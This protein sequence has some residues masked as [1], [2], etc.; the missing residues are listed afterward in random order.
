MPGLHKM[1]N[2]G[3]R[4]LRKLHEDNPEMPFMQ[5]LPI[6]NNEAAKRGW[7][8]LRSSGTIVYHLNVMGLYKYGERTSRNKY[9][10]QRFI[11]ADASQQEAI[12]KQFFTTTRTVRSAL[13]YETNSPFAK[14][15]RAYALNHGCKL[16]EV[17]L[18][19][20]PYEKTIIL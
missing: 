18:V 6:Y 11:K 2:E 9:R 15:L 8:S 12:A 4:F 13:N 19:D 16:Y 5:M 17:T 1:N 3:L 14:T 20:N 10:G 7:N